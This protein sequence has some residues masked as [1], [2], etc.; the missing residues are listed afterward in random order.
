M[1]DLI[2]IKIIA[3][4]T[5]IYYMRGENVKA[6]IFIISAALSLL[7][8]TGCSE[9]RNVFQP[10]SENEAVNEGIAQSVAPNTDAIDS[11]VLEIVV[12]NNAG[13]VVYRNQESLRVVT[14]SS[15]DQNFN[16]SDY[17]YIQ[18]DPK[19][20]HYLYKLLSLLNSGIMEF[21]KASFEKPF[22]N[23]V[24][25]LIKM[26]EHGNF[27]GALEF[28]LH[29]IYKHSYSWIRDRYQLSLVVSYLE[30]TK[31]MLNNPDMD[32]YDVDGM[33]EVCYCGRTS[34]TVITDLLMHH[35]GCT[36]SSSCLAKC[37]ENWGS[38]SCATITGEE[39]CEEKCDKLY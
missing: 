15:S 32:L 28:G 14:K 11:D 10:L 13:Y 31:W 9:D 1:V 5:Q 18:V 27:Y 16:I 2:C 19:Y 20:T 39:T 38:S 36:V 37:I 7:L 25:V 4:M 24:S 21:K 8:F 17:R 3:I 22:K 26:I 33:W 6:R 29:D 30:A 12:I 35:Y 34:A 23:K